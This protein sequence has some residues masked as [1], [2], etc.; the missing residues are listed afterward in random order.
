[1]YLSTFFNIPNTI[2][3]YRQPAKP[4]VVT[5][6][7]AKKLANHRLLTLGVDMKTKSLPPALKKRISNELND[8]RNKLKQVIF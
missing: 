6:K 3:I 2:Q 4:K 1:M 8:K 7:D 5:K